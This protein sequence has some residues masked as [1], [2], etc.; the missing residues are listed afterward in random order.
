[1][2]TFKSTTFIFFLLLLLMNLLVLTGFSVH[3]AFYIIL[4]ASYI[5]VS[6]VASFFICSGFHMKALCSRKTEQKV[7]AL[8][9]DDGPYRGN[10]DAILDVLKDRAKATFFCI[11]SKIQGNE[12]LLKRMHEEGH[13]VG[14][15]SYSHSN[16]FDLYSAKKMTKE[17][18]Q[19]EELIYGILGKK[20]LLFRPPY[21][22]I[23]PMLKRALGGFPY[24]IIGY[25]NRSLDTVTK[26]ENRVIERLIRK[27]KPGDVV[28]LHDTAPYSATL[29]EKFLYRLAEKGFIVIGL[30]E[31]FNILA[32]DE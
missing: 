12:S 20:P 15:H 29:L 31:L 21:G 3:F 24:H 11:G 25:S 13:L 22:V 2:F 5:T 4:I 7:I 6:V 1:M 23:N 27:L 16:W 30:D 9:Y 14:T 17:L 8:T 26:D 28:L 10:T 32:Y 18:K 19:S